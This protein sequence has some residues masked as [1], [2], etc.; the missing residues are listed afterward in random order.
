[1]RRLFVPPQLL[2]I[3]LAAFSD[4]PASLREL[5]HLQRIVPRGDVTL[6]DALDL[7]DNALAVARGQRDRYTEALINLCRADLFHRLE[8][9][10]D[11]LD[12]LQAAVQWLQYQ[13]VPTARY[14]EGI[15]LYFEAV[16]H[17]ILHADDKA[18]QHFAQAQSLLEESERYWMHHLGDT[19]LTRCQAAR[20][21]I[22]RL[23]DVR[24]QTRPGT[25]TIIVP[26]FTPAAGGYAP[27]I[28]ALVIDLGRL[29]L[30]VSMVDVYARP[31]WAPLDL[32]TVPLLLPR[33]GAYFIAVRIDRDG[34][35]TPESRCGDAVL[36]EVTTAEDAADV[37]ATDTP[38]SFVRES[39]GRIVFGS[40][41]RQGFA[42]KRRLLLRAAL[43]HGA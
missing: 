4:I 26:L 27:E 30:P 16:V 28:D 6:D 8:R 36:L 7:A 2:P 1:M 42:H 21:W 15:A 10:E 34:A 33:P 5:L 13:V 43:L 31:T 3:E 25:S 35:F 24:G 17:Y 38:Q 14:N 40:G 41:Q 12:A 29:R 22:A 37:L 9:W 11:A 18:M 32:E 23:V 20:H 39:Q 19:V